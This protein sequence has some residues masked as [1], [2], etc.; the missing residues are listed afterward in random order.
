MAAGATPSEPYY[1]PRTQPRLLK[2]LAPS[3]PALYYDQLRTATSGLSMVKAGGHAKCACCRC[4]WRA[5]DNNHQRRVMARKLDA[6]ASVWRPPSTVVAMAPL[7]RLFLSSQFGILDGKSTSSP[8]WLTILPS[9]SSL[10]SAAAL[11]TALL[12]FSALPVSPYSPL[13]CFAMVPA[14]CSLVPSSCSSNTRAMA[15][16]V[17]FLSRST[18]FRS[19]CLTRTLPFSRRHQHGDLPVLCWQW[20]HAHNDHAPWHWRPSCGPYRW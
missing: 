6:A 12:S 5:A 13:R 1:S 19:R 7:L 4:T 9:W 2:L 10:S 16:M 18:A 14:T 3:A 11:F 8:C 20:H 17:G 15:T